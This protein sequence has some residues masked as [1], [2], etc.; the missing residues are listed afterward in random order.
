MDIVI[1]TNAQSHQSCCSAKGVKL[2][3]KL[4]AIDESVVVRVKC[5]LSVA[6]LVEDNGSGTRRFASGIVLKAAR[7]HRA[8]G[9]SEQVLRGARTSQQ[10]RFS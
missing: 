10:V 1:V 6:L 9:G 4:T 5:L 2:N 3:H 7:F 8:D